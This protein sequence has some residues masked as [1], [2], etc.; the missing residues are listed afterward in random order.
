LNISGKFDLLPSAWQ[1]HEASTLRGVYE[2]A[3]AEAEELFIVSAFLTEWQSSLKLN[4]RCSAFL[5][6]VG[7]DFGTTR[8]AALEAALR[9]LPKRFPQGVLAF[10]QR[11]TAFHP[12]AMLWRERDGSCYMLVGSSNLTRAAFDSN[13]EAN[14]TLKLDEEDYLHAMTWLSDIADRSVEVNKTWL[15]TYVEAPVRGGNGNEGRKGAKRSEADGDGAEPIQAPVFDLSLEVRGAADRKLFNQYLAIRRDQKATFD[16]SAREPLI[17]LVLSSA[18]KA[19]WSKRDDQHFYGELVRLWGSTNEI[20]MGGDQWQMTGKHADY[21][22]LARSL[23]AVIEARNVERDAVVVRERDRL[24]GLRVPT[25]AAVFTELLCHLYPKRYP[26]LDAPVRA[27]RQHVGF[28]FRVGGSEGER[29][30]RLARAMR[31]ALRQ[32]G[33]QELGIKD[34]AELDVLIWLNFRRDGDVSPE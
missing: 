13:V 17:S 16:A 5:L 12:K 15:S 32:D 22:E 28:D 29:Y 8:R 30:L 26:I 19:S 20:R 7:A 34:L 21:R 2:R 3:F 23:K 11:G 6:I 24:H 1:G 33:P 31:A 25:R 14:V 18:T 10:N 27:W 9:W 4:P